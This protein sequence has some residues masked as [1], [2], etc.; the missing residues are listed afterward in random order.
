MGSDADSSEVKA[1]LQ[2]RALLS[3]GAIAQLLDLEQ[4]PGE[5]ICV[6]EGQADSRVGLPNLSIPELLRLCLAVVEGAQVLHAAGATVSFFGGQV[7]YESGQAR[8]LGLY[9]RR[10]VPTLTELTG[11]LAQYFGSVLE[12]NVLSSEAP[13]RVPEY[14]RTGIRR[15]LGQLEHPLSDLDELRVFLQTLSVENL[16][17]SRTGVIEALGNAA[18]PR[19]DEA[20]KSPGQRW[21]ADTGSGDGE[22]LYPD[23]EGD[24]ADSEYYEDMPAST[25]R[26]LVP[27]TIGLGVLAVAVLAAGFLI[28]RGVSS[29]T[30]SDATSPPAQAQGSGGTRTTGTSSSAGSSSVAGTG[31]TVQSKGGTTGKPGAGVTLPPSLDGA[32]VS[33]AV[34]EL[35]QLGIAAADVQVVTV[36]GAGDGVDVSAVSP[37]VGSHWQSGQ[38]VR[39]EVV[40]PSGDA[41][42]P[43][44]VGVSEASAIQM[45]LRDMFHFS[46]TVD[47]HAGVASGV[48]FAQNPSAYAVEA[49]QTTVTFRVAGHY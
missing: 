35:R 23:Y 31:G 38:V 33:Q 36:T 27:W 41:L 10:P 18:E 26:R 47:A 2:R 22:D 12:W 29:G 16:P 14:L 21:E 30:V 25:K 39:L 9:M 15:L 45:L 13:E 4:R 42:V 37:P 19:T 7:L 3:D 44:L 49:K 32:P 11:Q 17:E 1:W 20:S 48:V 43:D 46:Y 28:V 5:Y 24:E 8:W 40:V 6:F 34:H